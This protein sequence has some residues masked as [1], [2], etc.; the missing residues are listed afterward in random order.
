MKHGGYRN[1]ATYAE[2]CA[3]NNSGVDGQ[4]TYWDGTTRTIVNNLFRSLTLQRRP[5]LYQ[6]LPAEKKHDLKRR[7]DYVKIIKKLEDL[8]Q[9]P[10]KTEEKL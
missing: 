2:F 6:S 5:Y 1:P 10:E 3:P 7:E 4:A 9:N 8:N